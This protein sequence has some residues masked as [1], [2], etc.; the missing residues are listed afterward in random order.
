MEQSE[1][2]NLSEIR[3]LTAHLEVEPRLG[4]PLL[5]SRGILEGLVLVVG[6]DQVF[7]NSTRLGSM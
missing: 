5:L 2:R 4:D 1:V 3:S 6:I 7:Y